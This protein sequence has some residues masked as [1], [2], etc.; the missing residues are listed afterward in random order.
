MPSNVLISGLYAQNEG[1]DA[2]RFNG[3]YYY[4][5]QFNGKP[6]Y[7]FSTNNNIVLFYSGSVWSLIDYVANSG[8]GSIDN[9]DYPW[10]ITSWEGDSDPPDGINVAEAPGSNTLGLS[11]V[12]YEGYFDGDPQWFTTATRTSATELRSNFN[13]VEPTPENGY[14][15][16]WT[17]YFKPL[18]GP[19]GEIEDDFTFTMGS[20]DIGIM[21]VGNAALSGY[22]TAN[23]TVSAYGYD[24]SEPISLRA[25]TYYPVRIQF[26]H[27]IPPTAVSLQI[28]ANPTLRMANDFVAGNLFNVIGEDGGISEFQRVANL[29]GG[30]ANF[31]RMRLLG[32]F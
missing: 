1:R 31:L 25:D 29:H 4:T 28:Q 22:T 19:A 21:W 13:P 2:A 8:M 3:V 24:Q 23:R 15:W 7:V 18:P 9:V 27:P 20:D 32:Q 10:L 11:G 6:S 16:E 14:S 5:G 26:G 17:G 12:K 30:V